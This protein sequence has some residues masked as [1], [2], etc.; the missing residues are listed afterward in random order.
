MN[1]SKGFLIIHHKI[2]KYLHTVSVL[3][4]N[5]L[6]FSLKLYFCYTVGL[7]CFPLGMNQFITIT[8]KNLYHSI[9]CLFL[10]PFT[11]LHFTKH[12]SS[13]FQTEEDEMQ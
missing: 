4:N 10:L 1:L 6:I 3:T 11:P 8:A 7:C 5:L 13:L 12:H 9:L 2:L